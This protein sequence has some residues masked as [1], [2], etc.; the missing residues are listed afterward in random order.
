MSKIARQE[1]EISKL[2]DRLQEAHEDRDRYKKALM[3]LAGALTEADPSLTR[4]EMVK[5]AQEAIK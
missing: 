2:Y 1:Q 4:V 5:I 3:L